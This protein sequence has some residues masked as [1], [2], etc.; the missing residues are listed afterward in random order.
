MATYNPRF[1]IG[2]DPAL[3]TFAASLLRAPNDPNR[4]TAEFANDLDGFDAFLLWLSQH[5]VPT[6]ETIVCVEATGVY[7]VV[8]FCVS[9]HHMDN[10]EAVVERAYEMLPDG[11]HLLWRSNATQA[12]GQFVD[13]GQ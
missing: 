5:Q 11:G 12:N 8:L 3:E 10:L 9:M 4:V 1:F 6:E 7:D 2:I 13:F